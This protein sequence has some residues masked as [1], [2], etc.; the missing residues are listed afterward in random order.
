MTSGRQGQRHCWGERPRP[1]CRDQPTRSQHRDPVMPGVSAECGPTRN[2]H[3]PWVYLVPMA[4]GSL[5][6][7]TALSRV[8]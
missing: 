7:L 6:G 3:R 2:A 5:Q 4:W 8:V 1:D